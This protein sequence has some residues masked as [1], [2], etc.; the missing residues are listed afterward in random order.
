M[1][2][3]FF[4][5][6]GI[7]SI[8]KIHSQII[9][10]ILSKDN[11][12]ILD[13]QK[14]KIIELLFEE[15]GFHIDEIHTEYESID[16]L[17]KSSE[18]VICIENKLKS[19]QHSNQ[20]E[21]YEK[22][23]LEKYN[24]IKRKF[25]YLTLIGESSKLDTWKNITYNQLHEVLSEIPIQSNTNGVILKE[26]IKTLSNF[27]YIV[28]DFL[29][30]PEDYP[31]VF[32]SGSTKKSQKNQLLDNP[33]MNFISNNQLETIFQ[34]MYFKSVANFLNLEHYYINET[35]GNAILG[36]VIEHKFEFK[37]KEYNLGFDF[38]KGAFKTF[39]TT[40]NYYNSK[41]QD[42]P[43]EIVNIIKSLKNKKDYGYSRF[44]KPRTKAQYSLTK[45]T[46]HSFHKMKIQQFAILFQNEL[47]LSKKMIREEILIRLNSKEENA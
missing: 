32:L 25:F 36:V 33:K 14:S 5:Y 1:N 24:K 28:N 41:P 7:A 10:W 35:R 40:T 22:I 47:D 27:K 19:S 8:E 23:I 21:K 18:T 9:K 16:I 38:Q 6:L 17:I 43:D 45:R 12:A 31:N 3:T 13:S 42:I 20:L 44:N 29:K 15:K 39:C 34:K 46:P 26:Y 2:R 37:G 4:E 11:N 30:N